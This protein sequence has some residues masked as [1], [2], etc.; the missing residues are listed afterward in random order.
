MATP[1]VPQD[2][3]GQKSFKKEENAFRPTKKD[4]ITGRL[5]FGTSA[6]FCAHSSHFQA[7]FKEHSAFL[8]CEEPRE[9]DL[10]KA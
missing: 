2:R 1:F 10:F 7:Y 3:V 6:M 9:E 5:S 4:E 8:L